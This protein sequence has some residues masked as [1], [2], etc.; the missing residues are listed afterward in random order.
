M[1]ASLFL[2][3]GAWIDPMAGE[4]LMLSFT[5]AQRIVNTFAK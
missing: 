2:T 5:A 3:L 4:N 1:I